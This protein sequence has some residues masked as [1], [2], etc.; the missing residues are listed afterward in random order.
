MQP[1]LAR[2]FLALQA[3]HT[4]RI[5]IARIHIA[6]VQS[7][8]IRQAM[9]ALLLAVSPA[10]FGLQPASFAYSTSIIQTDLVGLESFWDLIFPTGSDTD[11]LDNTD[12]L[13]TSIE[14][15]RLLLYDR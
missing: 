11:G 1:G 15:K 7:G 12:G 4:A 14:T 10:G 8:P 2:L 6:K 3:G 13:D 5:H 9:L